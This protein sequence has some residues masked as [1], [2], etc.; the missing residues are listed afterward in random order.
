M[1]EKMCKF[2]ELYVWEVYTSVDSAV[3]WVYSDHDARLC[4]QA[5]LDAVGMHP[6][7]ERRHVDVSILSKD[8]VDS[9][10]RGSAMDYLT[11]QTSRYVACTARSCMCC[12]YL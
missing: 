6:D 2:V 12:L 9:G 3:F 11:A 7:F 10:Q 1:L 4:L 5:D 8:L